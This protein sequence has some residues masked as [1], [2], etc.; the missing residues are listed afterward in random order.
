MNEIV[1]KAFLAGVKFIPNMHL[2]QPGFTYSDLWT[3]YKKTKR[4]YKNLKKEK[5]H[6][7]SIKLNQIK[8][9]FNMTWVTNILNI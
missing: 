7:I 6:N 3:I 2:R 4:V 5:I 9:V 1:K 8:L